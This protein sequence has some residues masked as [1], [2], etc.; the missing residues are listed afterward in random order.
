LNQGYEEHTT[1]TKVSH[2]LYTDDLKLIGKGR[3]SSKKQM[4]TEPS[5]MISMWNS[6]LTSV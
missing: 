4:Q 6:D 1:K 2:I 3:K 5:V